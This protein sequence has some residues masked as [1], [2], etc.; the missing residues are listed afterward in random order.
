LSSINYG[1]TSL[2]TQNMHLKETILK[3]IIIFYF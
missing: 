1:R 2:S 3:I